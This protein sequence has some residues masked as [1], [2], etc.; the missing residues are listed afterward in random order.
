M[1]MMLNRANTYLSLVGLGWFVPIVRMAKGEDPAEQARLV[2]RQLGIPVLA[3]A[4]F[5]AAWSQLGS[6]RVWAPS[7]GRSPSGT[8]R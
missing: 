8:R 2:W 5:V 6:I 4:F 7:R 1:Q 3:I